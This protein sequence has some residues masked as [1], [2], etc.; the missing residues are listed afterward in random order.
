MQQRRVRRDLGRPRTSTVA[1]ATTS[2]RTRTRWWPTGDCTFARTTFGVPDS[3]RWVETSRA[4]LRVAPM[5]S[6]TRTTTATPAT[7]ESSRGPNWQPTSIGQHF[8]NRMRLPLP[9][10]PYEST[11]TLGYPSSYFEII[12]YYKDLALFCSISYVF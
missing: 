10:I 12:N 9:R 2:A 11:Q 7:A 1:S 8:P 3:G 6:G 4:I 5:P